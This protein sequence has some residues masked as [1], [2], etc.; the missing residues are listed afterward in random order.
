VIQNEKKKTKSEREAIRKFL[1][2]KS[3]LFVK[4]VTQKT[5]NFSIFVCLEKCLIFGVNCFS[6]LNDL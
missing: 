5:Q 2:E 3:P 6:L 1:A 4:K